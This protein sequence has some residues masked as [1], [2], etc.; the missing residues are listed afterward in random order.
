MAS[1]H[2]MD[3]TKGSV[4]KKLVV[5]TLPILASNM[6]QQLYHAADVMVVGK[7]A[8]DP[9]IALAAVG[10][11]GALTTLLLNIFLGLSIGANVA[12]ANCYGS[13]DEKKLRQAMYTSLILAVGGGIF[14][15]AMGVIFA[16]PLLLMTGCPETV[17]GEA[18]K[19]MQI[20]F[21]G[22]PFNLLFNF[23][24]GILRSHGDSKR[25]MYILTIA[26]LINVLFNALGVIIFLPFVIAFG[27]KITEYCANFSASAIIAYFHVAFNLITTVLLL[28]FTKKIADISILLI[29][30]KKNGNILVLE[31]K[32]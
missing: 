9:V 11:S 29:P 18:T 13:G 5:F 10:S 25:P 19:Y 28:P 21:L 3:Q 30:D 32:M 14:V 22:Q 1:A 17:I 2:V 26:G 4:F 23:G 8:Q 6:L 31:E 27:R 16:R 15:A 7:F 20:I 12:C 24:A